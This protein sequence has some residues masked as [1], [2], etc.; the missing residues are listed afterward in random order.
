MTTR[1]ITLVATAVV[2]VA[3]TGAA[4]AWNAGRGVSTQA[5]AGKPDS[6]VIEL[7]RPELHTISPRGLVDTIRFT[8]TTQPKS[9][10]GKVIV[11]P[12]GKSWPA[13]RR[14]NC[15]RKSTNGDLRWK[16]PGPTPDGRRA[17]APTRSLWRRETSC[18]NRR[19]IRHVPPPRTGLRWSRWPRRN[20]KSP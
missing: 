4:V 6:Q 12:R 20:S 5:A 16:Q 13:S 19:P 14:R 2:V 15:R 18:R 1:R 7:I 3:L 10:S 11:L 8:G 17:T 9:W